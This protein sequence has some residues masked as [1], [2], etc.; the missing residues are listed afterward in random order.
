MSEAAN[1]PQLAP[2]IS[3][4]AT[5]VVGYVAHNEI[6]GAALSNVIQAVY[7][8]L[9]ALAEEETPSRPP[10]PAVD[11]K[12]SVFPDYLICLED[13]KH[14]AMLRRHL[15]DAFGMTPNEY[16]LKWGLPGNYPMTAPNYSRKRR[17]MAISMGLGVRKAAESA[18]TTKKRGS[19]RNK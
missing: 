3:N 2:F 16:R 19:G 8:T 9:R 17:E 10:V 18:A 4:T 14:L 13:G 15:M 6:P 11:P 12:K 1:T 5:I 7:D